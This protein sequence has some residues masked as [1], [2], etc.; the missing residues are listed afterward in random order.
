MRSFLT[1]FFSLAAAAALAVG[2]GAATSRADESDH[3]TLEHEFI[4]ITSASLQPATL[5]LR[6][7]E[8]I[9]WLNYSDKIARVSFPRDVG[10]HLTCHSKGSFRLTGDRLESGDIQ[11]RQ[12]ASLCQLAPG[13][14]SYRVEL[15]S[16][17]G[18][19]GGGTVVRS[20]EGT[21]VVTK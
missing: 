5:E 16:G 10:K 15:R 19:S 14:Y 3:E 20:L 1:R 17:A 11:A 9:G 18:A 7:D 4:R 2:L 12:F 21:L 6:S 13:E 8:A